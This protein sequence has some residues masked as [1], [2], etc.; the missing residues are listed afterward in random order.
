MNAA[1]ARQYSE[2]FDR[3]PSEPRVCFDLELSSCGATASCCTPG[4]RDLKVRYKQAA[5]G[6]AWA[7]IQPLFAVLIFTVI[8]GIF[9]R[10][11]SDGMPYPVFAFAAVLPWTYFAEALRRGGDR[12]GDRLRTGAQDLLPAADHSARGRDR[13][14]GRSSPSASI[15]MLG[16][17]MA[18][19]GI[20]PTLESCWSCRLVA[21]RHAAGAG[22]GPVARADQRALPRRH[23]HAAVP[24]AGL[25]VRLA[26]RL[27][28]QHGA[29]EVAALYSLNPMV[30]VIEGFRWALLGKGQPGFRRASA[31]AWL[32][33]LVALVGGCVYF[34]KIGTR[35]SRT[36][37]E[38]RHRHPGRAASASATSAAP[39]ATDTTR[40]ASCWS[41][42]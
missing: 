42:A 25:D 31:S 34:Q 9:A 41:P 30:G 1:V 18:W 20:A 37:Y 2:P 24:A 3:D 28:T 26:D 4:V 27:S 19:Y 17:M 40:S 16:L 8:F 13:A 33:S 32:S 29:R 36:S 12:P 5:L 39:P 10:M 7:I 15:V 23:A 38:Q 14:A 21:D 35:R 11:P 6:V 22:G